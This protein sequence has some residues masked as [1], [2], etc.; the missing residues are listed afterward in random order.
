MRKHS[1]RT[2]RKQKGGS[3]KKCVFIDNKP[4][5]G[6]GNQ[7]FIYA[8]GLLVKKHAD[9]ELCIF[10]QLDNKHSPKDYRYLFKEA[11][12][13]ERTSEMLERLHT[14]L[15]VHEHRK[16]LQHG[17]WNV[18][19][20]PT[21]PND[22]TL[23]DNGLYQ[24][25][26]MI[27]PVISLIRAP[28][29]HDLNTL[30]KSLHIR[31]NS[32][33]MHIRRGDL[34]IT[35]EEVKP[36]YLHNSLTHFEVPQIH[37]IYIIVAD[38]ELEWSKAQDFKTTKHIEWFSDPDELKALYVMSKCK[39]GGIISPSTFSTWGAILG[40]D[41]NPDSIIIYPKVWSHH[42]KEHMSF[43]SRWIPL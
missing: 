6:L 17:D 8:A 22:I 40:P 39:A 25:Y 31:P 30:Y 19:E 21:A 12:S 11:K 9:K 33:F 43:P 16:D 32:A 18:K 38:Y 37:T 23:K 13:V 34:Q 1:R 36:E 5:L 24:N 26:A 28:L 3:P 4:G 20:I 41:T 2:R 29:K 14:S 10:H 35:N 15:K 27:K 42:Y 7:L